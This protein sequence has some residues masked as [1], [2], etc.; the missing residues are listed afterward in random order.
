MLSRA[1]IPLF[2]LG[3]VCCF[4]QS[5]RQDYQ[6]FYVSPSGSPQGNGSM[7]SP[8]DLQ[9]A[10]SQPAAVKPGDTIWVRGGT[11]GN[12]TTIFYSR[13]VGTAFAPIIVRQFPNERAT[14]D[15]WLQVGCCDQNPQPAMGSYVWFWG[16]E[17]A[18]SITDRTGLPDGTSKILD[19][20][21][22]WALGS[23]FINN[24]VHDTRNGFGMW[25]EAPNSEAYGNV[26][27]FNG[28][29]ASDRGHGH[30][31][32]VQNNTG[33]KT[34]ADNI[35]FDQF[36]N[37]I[38]FYGTGNSNVKNVIAQGNI[39]FNNGAI[40]TPT[41][42]GPAYAD[43]LLFAIGNGVQNA[44]VLNNYLYFTPSLDVGNNELGYGG[45]PNGSLIATGNYFIGGFEAVEVGN[46]ASV[47]F[48]GN[49]IYSKDKFDVLMA[50]TSPLSGYAW[51]KNTYYGAGLFQLNSSGTFFSGWPGKTGFDSQ[52]T[53]TSGAP[54]GVWTFLES[55]KY[56]SGRANIVIYNWNLA[57]SVSVDVHTVLTPG[58]QYEVLD[59]ENF[60]GPPVASGIY[61][62]SPIVIPMTGLTMA[63]PNGSVPSAA[64]HT[65][66]AF[67]AFVLRRKD[68]TPPTPP[69][70]HR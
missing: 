47:T 24:I 14:I 41:S 4:G 56:E 32:Y 62:G 49:T 51:N 2:L 33:T 53:Y 23:K 66:P 52:S 69:G 9:T 15:G 19:A 22:T 6:D 34:I 67:G 59:A 42:A 40:A 11:Y 61:N 45:N 64:S 38:Q 35:I 68:E 7:E 12:G 25:Q 30:G 10:L 43:N 20:I 21:D 46:W 26:V 39:S 60:F 37:G 28:F 29:Q 48:Q 55:N 36:D 27:Y 58:T 18:S 16:L 65:A 44:Q 5:R 8:W 3:L 13:L 31:F 63:V 54:T 57:N 17:F 70:R 1:L 50:D